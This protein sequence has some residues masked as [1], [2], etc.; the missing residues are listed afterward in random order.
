M[1]KGAHPA[2]GIGDADGGEQAKRLVGASRG[3]GDLAADPHGRVQRGHRILENRTQ[4]E[5]ADLAQCLGLTGD[6]VRSGDANGAID[7]RVLGQQTQQGEPEDALAGTG[8]AHQAEDLAG[9][10]VE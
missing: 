3:L 7:L 5:P 8:F 10:D 6:H 1:R 2:L 4:V 9:H